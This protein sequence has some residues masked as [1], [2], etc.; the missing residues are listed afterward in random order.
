[1]YDL[2]G[3][4]HAAFLNGIAWNLLNLSIVITL[5]WRTRR[6]LPALSAG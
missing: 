6:R 5:L 4:Y 1:V 3:S 2:T